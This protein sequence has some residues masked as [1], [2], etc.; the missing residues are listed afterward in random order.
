MKPVK[1][2]LGLA[3]GSRQRS[4]ERARCLLMQSRLSDAYRITDKQE[5]YAQVDVIKSETIATLVAEDETL[6]ANELGEILHAI[7]KNVVRSRV[8]AGEP[9]IDGREKDMI[10]GLDVRTGVLPRTHGSAL[11]TRG[12][13]QA[14]VTAT[15]G[16]A[17]D[18]QNIDELMG[19]RTDSFLFHYN[20]PP[21]SVGETG[22][23]GSPKRREIGDGRLA[24]RGVLAVMPTIEEFPY[25]VRVV[26]EITESNGSSSMASVC[27][28]SLA[29]MD[30]GVPVK[31]AVAG[32][33]MGLVKEGDN[34]VVLSDILGD[35][36][37][38]GDMDFKVAGSANG[39]SAMDEPQI[40]G[41]TKEIMQVAL[42]QAKGARLHILGVMEQAINAPR[43]DISEFAPRIHTIKINPDKIK[44]VIGKGGSVIRA[45]TE[46]TGT[47]IE[48]EDDGTVKIAA[49]DGDK[50]QHAIRRIEEITAEIGKVGRICRR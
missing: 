27:G 43:G 44:D 4:A 9:R 20:F 34:F 8:L 31:A 3:A 29:L 47:T 25:T 11:F 36:D 30:A 26:S 15:L 24:K 12:E 23:V 46:E 32:I 19:E 28:A 39:I 41:I 37:H 42:N 40:E 50:A 6:D 33:A 2:T 1:T 5:R 14:L 21:Y 18:A 22:M 49:T 13:T 16:T 35:E 10:R 38:L 45:L 7:E 17:R 48:I